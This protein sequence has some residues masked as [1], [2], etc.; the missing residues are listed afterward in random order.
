MDLNLLSG[1]WAAIE[2]LLKAHAH[3]EARYHFARTEQ[4]LVAHQSSL[5]ASAAN[6]AAVRATTGR[7]A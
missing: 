1:L 3:S 6:A 5:M 7:A 2:P 4:Q